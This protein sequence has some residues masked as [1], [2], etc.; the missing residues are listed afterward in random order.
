[1]LQTS[2]KPYP[3]CHMNHAFLDAV[4]T[5][6]TRYRFEPADVAAVECRI[7]AREAPIVCEP[8]ATKRTPQTDYDAKFSLPYTVACMLI[9]GHVEVDDF[10]PAAIRDAAVLSLAQRVRYGDDP[11]SDYPRHFPGRLRIHLR[12]GTV[13]EHAEPVHRG[14]P[15]RPLSDDEVCDKFTRNARRSLTERN[16]AAVAEM[17]WQLESLADVRAVAAALRGDA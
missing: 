10:T 6:R 8:E 16:A 9:R 3:C 13:L 17:I 2:L 4:A 11:E 1:M 12:N 7:A 15:D 14:S 5:L